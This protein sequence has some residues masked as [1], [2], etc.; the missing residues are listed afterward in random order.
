MRKTLATVAIGAVAVVLNWGFVGH[1]QAIAASAN[2]QEMC[3][4]AGYRQ[5]T[6]LTHGF[7]QQNVDLRDSKELG[8][9]WYN[10]N[11]KQHQAVSIG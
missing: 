4:K 5:I 2:F 3:N 1:A 6:F 10:F 9:K 8:Y 7:S 11:R